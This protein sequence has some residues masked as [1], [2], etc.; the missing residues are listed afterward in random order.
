MKKAKKEWNK[1]KYE[2]WI[3]RHFDNGNKCNLHVQFKLHADFKM[4]FLHSYSHLADFSNFR[5]WILMFHFV[6]FDL[7]NFS[8]SFCIFNLKSDCF[9]FVY[10]FG[11][12]FI[13]FFYDFVNAFMIS[14]IHI[15]GRG[16]SSYSLF[17]CVSSFVNLFHLCARSWIHVPLC[18]AMF[19]CWALVFIIKRQFEN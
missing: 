1:K 2:W 14:L 13:F 19:C 18:L 16:L 4:I 8:Q 12:P 5:Y 7:L 17:F 15:H 3:L 6:R 11:F 9:L 10:V